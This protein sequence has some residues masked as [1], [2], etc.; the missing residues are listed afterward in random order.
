MAVDLERRVKGW[1]QTEK[2]E[3]ALVL[4]RVGGGGWGGGGDCP[5]FLPMLIIFCLPLINQRAGVPPVMKTL[6]HR[7]YI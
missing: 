7:V 4:R 6:N 1:C 5:T 2:E 3:V